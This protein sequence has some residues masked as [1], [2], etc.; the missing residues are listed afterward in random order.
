ML[1]INNKKLFGT[2]NQRCFYGGESKPLEKY[3]SKKKTQ[4]T[5]IA[6]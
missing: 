2:I 3:Y 6:S 1:L 5:F 4:F